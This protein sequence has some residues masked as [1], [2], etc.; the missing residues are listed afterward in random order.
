MNLKQQKIEAIK[1]VAIYLR[2]SDEKKVRGKRVSEEET[3]QNHYER[4]TKFCAEKGYEYEVFKEVVSGGNSLEERPELNKMLKRIIEFD[5][6]V[7]AEDSR[8]SRNDLVSA[9]IA[10]KVEKF[11]KLIMTPEHVYYLRDENDR[12]VFNVSASMNSNER[13]KIAKRVRF[14]KLEM[15]R[16]GLNASGSVPLGYKRN[17]ETKKLEIDEATAHIPATAFYLNSL[18]YGSLKIRDILNDMGFKTANGALWTNTTVK[19]LLKK[20]TYKGFTVYNDYENYMTIDKNGEEKMKKR[21]KDTISTPNTHPA[22][23]APEK[24]DMLQQQ[25]AKRGAAYGQNK[26][27]ERAHTKTEPSILKDLIYCASCGRKKRIS[28]EGKKNQW[29]IRNCGTD[30]T[31]SD[32]TRCFDNGFKA[33]TLEEKVIADVFEYKAKLEKEIE[34]LLNENHE[35]IDAQNEQQKQQLEKQIND[36]NVEAKKLAR[37]KIQ[38]MKEGDDLEKEIIQEEIDENKHALI[39]LQQQLEKLNQIMKEPKAEEEIKKRLSVIDVINNMENETDTLKINN[40]LKRF[41]YKIHY[42]RKIPEEIAKLGTKHPKRDEV[43]PVIKFE[44]IR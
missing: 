29:L 18:G 42:S 24:F 6:I 36:L 3:L 25:R 28:Y 26:S 30:A 40:F 44:Y 4:C 31:L 23:I 22:I 32:G 7:V 33:K 10:D 27:R 38:L 9:Q 5:A 12:F 43:E 1:K 14:G 35:E 16:R 21:K 20:E 2:I 37:V 34:M 41:I 17:P 39:K 11:D 8:L 15:A 13:M 19:D